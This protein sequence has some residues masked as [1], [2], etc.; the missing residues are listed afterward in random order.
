MQ[1]KILDFASD[2]IV[3]KLNKVDKQD[4][5]NVFTKVSSKFI[6]SEKTSQ[7]GAAA[8]GSTSQQSKE[9]VN[10]D[11]KLQAIDVERPEDKTDK[12]DNILE[13]EKDNLESEGMDESSTDGEHC[14]SLRRKVLRL[15]G[16]QNFD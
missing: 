14:M 10:E 6:R 8:Q 11:V 15:R 13:I 7:K 9:K 3:S 2:K 12:T 5:K 1:A 16:W 4:I